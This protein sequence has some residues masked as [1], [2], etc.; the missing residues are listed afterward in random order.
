MA[1]FDDMKR[2]SFLVLLTLIALF[3]VPVHATCEDCPTRTPSPTK[4]TE[5]P[6][7]EAR[8]ATPTVTPSFTITPTP[9]PT[10]LGTAT[11][12]PPLT[13]TPSFTP[14]ITATLTPSL[15]PISTIT[16]TPMPFS[17]YLPIVPANLG[18]ECADWPCFPNANAQR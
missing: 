10:K 17:L 15:T 8:T 13:S 5:T 3:S 6:T 11:T 9:F 14:S 12:I 1:G 7:P 2:L 18:G 16:P 4:F